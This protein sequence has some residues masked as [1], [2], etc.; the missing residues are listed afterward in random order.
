MAC[1]G[2]AAAAGIASYWQLARVAAMQSADRPPVQRHAAPRDD[3]ANW[4]F[5]QRN[6]TEESEAA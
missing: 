6:A 5:F 4:A 2:R 3:L 1:P